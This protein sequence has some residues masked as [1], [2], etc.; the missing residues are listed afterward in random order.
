[1]CIRDRNICCV[2]DDDQSIYSWRGADVTN[3][4]NFE[5]NFENVT[6]VRL[7]QN[8]RSTRNIL[9]C[10]ST[11]I[12]KN[13]GRY[14]KELWSKNQIGEKITINGFWETKEESIFVTDKIENIIKEKKKLN[15]ISILFRVAAHTRSF[16][17]RL[18]NLG[19]PYKIIGGLPVSY[20]HLTLPTKA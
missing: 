12:E 6:I 11:L 1:M 4:L 18:I 17:E 7:E 15:E 10:A 20:T 9:S 5:K 3:L 2:G 16:E 19:L 8:Y 13:K 14:G